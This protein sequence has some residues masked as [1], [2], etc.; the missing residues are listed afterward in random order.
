[1]LTWKLVNDKPI[2][3][4]VGA[5]QAKYNRSSQTQQMYYVVM[6]LTGDLMSKWTD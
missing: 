6:S 1:L 5:L 2:L 4:S 3:S